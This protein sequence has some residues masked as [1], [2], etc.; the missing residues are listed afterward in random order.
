MSDSNTNW[1]TFNV[2]CMCI[3]AKLF[4]LHPFLW[5]FLHPLSDCLLFCYCCF[6]C[7][8]CLWFDADE[9]ICVPPLLKINTIYIDPNDKVTERGLMVCY[10]PKGF[11]LMRLNTLAMCP[12]SWCPFNL[13]D[14]LPASNDFKQKLDEWR[15]NKCLWISGGEYLGS[16][17]SWSAVFQFQY[18]YI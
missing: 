11:V 12:F 13:D 9:L 17:D 15:W 1:R 14:P 5:L 18:I 3:R 16:V 2:L 6:C 8:C 7:C 10:R 4:A